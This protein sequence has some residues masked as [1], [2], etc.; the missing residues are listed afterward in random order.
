[1]PNIDEMMDLH[2]FSDDVSIYHILAL[3]FRR[4][5]RLEELGLS[6]ETS[7]PIVYP[8]RWGVVSLPKFCGHY[9][10]LCRHTGPATVEYFPAG[11]PMYRESL[12]IDNMRM[13]TRVCDALNGVPGR[14]Q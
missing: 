12:D 13:A 6:K 1:M 8:T 4:L 3:V 5:K 10:R 11:H 7:P 9:Y 14:G 2:Q